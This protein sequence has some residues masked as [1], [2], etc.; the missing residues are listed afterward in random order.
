L[1]V[2]ACLYGF[3]SGAFVSMAPALIAQISPD[4][5]K[6]GVRNGSTFAVISLAVLISN[7]IAGAIV[8]AAGGKFLG[9]MIY[10]GVVQLAGASL[11]LVVKFILGGPN[12]LAKV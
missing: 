11:L 3:G 9:L 2:F 8:D 4:I 12:I 7:P 1:I 10:C 6:I 5:T